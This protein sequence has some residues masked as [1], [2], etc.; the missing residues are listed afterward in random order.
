MIKGLEYWEGGV[1]ILAIQ[2]IIIAT[3]NII[4]KKK[5]NIFLGVLLLIYVDSI[6]NSFLYYHIDSSAVSMI[7]GNLHLNFFYGPILYLYVVSLIKPKAISKAYYSHLVIP[8]VLI[9]GILL[10]SILANNGIVPLRRNIFIYE[11]KLMLAVIYFIKGI[12]I[13][14]G[15]DW[16][17]IKQE[18]RYRLF[19]YLFGLLIIYSGVDMLLLKYIPARRTFEFLSYLD[20]LTYLAMYMYLIYYGFTELN[21]V[22]GRITKSQTQVS[23][24][25][26]SDTHERLKERLERVFEKDKIHTKKDLNM[27]MLAE[28][29]NVRNNVLSDYLNVFLKKSFYEYIN[30]KR[31][32]EF[33]LN[34]FK[35][36]YEHLDLIGIAYESGFNSKATFNRAF[37]RIE[38]ITPKQYRSAHSPENSKT[39]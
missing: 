29:V 12:Q 35:P 9:L 2:L 18:R 25:L 11:S 22:K 6:R 30:E 28:A 36:E 5:Q 16:N 17:N 34:V 4:T 19:F 3:L 32:E 33:K 31:V 26:D 7:I 1:Y 37:K 14:R 15:Q 8:V 20:I 21:W 24:T 38:G 39:E 23:P 13:I 10:Y 27:A